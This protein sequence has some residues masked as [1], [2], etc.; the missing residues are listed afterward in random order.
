MIISTNDDST[1]NEAVKETI[2]ILNK[3][4]DIADKF[5]NGF[6]SDEVIQLAQI[7]ALNKITNALGELNKISNALG[8]LNNSLGELNNTLTHIYLNLK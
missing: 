1:T 5:P 4:T 3:I 7:T 8:E 2:N 6:S